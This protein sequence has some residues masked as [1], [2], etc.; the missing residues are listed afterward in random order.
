MHKITRIDTEM[1]LWALAAPALLAFIR[2][3]CW[4]GVK[5]MGAM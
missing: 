3:V 2:L 5:L 1:L 4:A